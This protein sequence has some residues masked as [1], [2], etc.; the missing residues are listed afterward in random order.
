MTFKIYFIV[1]FNTFCVLDDTFHHEEQPPSCCS[2]SLCSGAAPACRHWTL[3]WTLS[4]ECQNLPTTLLIVRHRLHLLIWCLKSCIVLYFQKASVR[5]QSWVQLLYVSRAEWVLMEHWSCPSVS[6]RQ[7]KSAC[8]VTDFFFVANLSTVD[9]LVIPFVL[10]KETIL[11]VA[12]IA[13]VLFH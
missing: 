7:R 2:L 9:G 10:Q 1:P 8:T 4:Q 6:V 3:S 13:S 5:A 12:I 11:P